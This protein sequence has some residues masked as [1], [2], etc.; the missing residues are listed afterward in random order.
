MIQNLAGSCLFEDC[1][2]SCPI[3]SFQERKPCLALI[4]LEYCGNEVPPGDGLSPL[5]LEQ[6]LRARILQ[7]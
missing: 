6:V 5:N 3:L 7:S 4:G 1:S 2:Q